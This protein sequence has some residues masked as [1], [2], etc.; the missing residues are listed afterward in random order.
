MGIQSRGV[1]IAA[2]GERAT[3]VQV[4]LGGNIQVGVQVLKVVRVADVGVVD[5]GEPARVQAGAV[6]PAV[7]PALVFIL[8][9]QLAIVVAVV[10]IGRAELPLAAAGQ[11]AELAFHQ[12]AAVGHQVRIQRGVEVR[13]QVEVVRRLQREPGVARRA[14]ARGEKAGLATIIDREV[15]VRGV[16]HRYVLHPQRHVGRRAEAGRR[17]QRHVVALQMPGVLARLAAGVGTVLEPDDRGFLAL[18]IERAAAHLARVHHIL[19]VLDL[20]FAVVEE[21]FRA[22]P[23]HQRIAVTQTDVADQLAAVFQLVQAGLVGLGLHAALAQHHVTGQGGDFL[24]LFVARGLGRNVGRR[25][26]HRRIV[27]LARAVG[28]DVGTGAV[29]AGFGQLRGGELFARHPVQ[30]AVVLAA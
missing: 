18:G 7:H 16:E 8:G 30:M 6:L 2:V 14:D 19:G 28:L 11:V 12:Q 9:L 3:L 24:F 26:A 5:L 1:V 21:D 23:H 22:I 25:L 20:G 4:L 10:Q 27:E 13:C 15:D 29:G 17:V